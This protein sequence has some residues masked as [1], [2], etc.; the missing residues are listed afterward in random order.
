[1]LYAGR[2]ARKSTHKDVVITYNFRN[3]KWFLEG[4]EK[5]DLQGALR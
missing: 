5:N 2:V 1:M 4:F 3:G